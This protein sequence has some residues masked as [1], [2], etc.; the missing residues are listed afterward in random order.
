MVKVI[1][2]NDGIVLTLVGENEE[3]LLE[4]ARAEIEVL[5]KKHYE[6]CKWNYSAYEQYR[7]ICYWHIHDVESKEV[8]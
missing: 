5:A 7:N 8:L 1:C 6:S 3:V 4:Q 2:M